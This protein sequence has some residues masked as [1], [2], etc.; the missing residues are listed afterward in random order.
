MV[1]GMTSNVG[2]PPWSDLE[3][4]TTVREVQALIGASENA[5][6]AL[7]ED[8]G[9]WMAGTGPGGQ[10]MLIRDWAL[11]PADEYI[12]AAKTVDVAAGAAPPVGQPNEGIV[13]LRK[14]NIRERVSMNLLWRCCNR[15]MGLDPPPGSGRH[16]FGKVRGAHEAKE[17]RGRHCQRSRR[18]LPPCPWRDGG[19]VYG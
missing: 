7:A 1:A 12:A 4:L 5:W 8:F 9:F 6:K 3:N 11:V 13:P 14:L 15:V 16:F 18:T 17:H 10:I 19:A 2:I